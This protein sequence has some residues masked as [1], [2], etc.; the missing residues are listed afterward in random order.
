MAEQPT[1]LNAPLPYPPP[2]LR[3]SGSLGRFELR[4]KLGQGAQ[5]T[6]WLAHD[7]RMERDVAI[8]VLRPVTGAD[9]QA[10][11]QWLQE[12]RSVGRVK[13]ANIVPVYEADTEGAYAFLVFEYV[14]GDTLAQLLSRKGCC[15][16]GRQWVI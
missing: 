15:R 9:Q 7:P 6:V 3:P 13:H 14:A 12:A 5:S 2:V 8:K 1:N 16:R 4:R 10:I 11:G